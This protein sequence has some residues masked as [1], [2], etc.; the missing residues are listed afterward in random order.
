[1]T[2]FTTFP[3]LT[4]SGASGADSLTAQV[5]TSPRRPYCPTDP[6]LRRMQE[7]RLAPELSATSRIVPI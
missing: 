7:R 5:M 2:A 4:A 3:F 1:M 6:P